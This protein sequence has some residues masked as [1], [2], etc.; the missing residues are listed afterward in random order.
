MLQRMLDMLPFP[1]WWLLVPV[2]VVVVAAVVFGLFGTPRGGDS[3]DVQ[4]GRSQRWA[5][6]KDLAPLLYDDPRADPRRLVL[7]RFAD[8]WVLHTGLHRSVAVVA[9]A[10]RGKTPRFV[11]PT[12]LRYPGPAFVTSTKFDCG[13]LTLDQREELGPVWLVDPAG[14]TGHAPARWSVLSHVNDYEEAVNIAWL[15][16]RS[17]RRVGGSASSNDEFWASMSRMLLG[18]CLLAASL[19][20]QSMA[21]VIR[22]IQTHDA[23]SVEHILAE[24]DQPAALSAWA[25]FSKAEE[26]TRA[27][28]LTSATSILEPWT[29]PAIARMAE[30]TGDGGP[31]IDLDRLLDENGTIY[32]I[33]S[34]EQQQ[35]FSPIF[36]LLAGLVVA[37][38]G[39]RSLRNGGLPISPPLL[40]LLDEAAN[41]CRVRDLD[42]W[43]SS[44]AGQGMILVS[45]WQDEAQ[46]VSAYGQSKAKE[47]MAN[48]A[49]TVYLPGISDTDTLATI[50]KKVGTASFQHHSSSVS[51]G[52]SRDRGSITRSS[53][54]HDVAPAS[55]LQDNLVDGQALL[56]VQG[57]KPAIVQAPGWWERD[58]LRALIPAKVAAGFDNLYASAAP[59]RTRLSRVLTG[60]KG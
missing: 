1:L 10:G 60:K 9:P 31:V 16:S 42:M 30:V 6:K 40:M 24:F 33:C 38:I 29:H 49:A 17:S 41:V 47:I 36:E 15:L 27:N 19:A 53:S 13:A 25:A 44:M 57:F 21:S 50:T 39:Q 56:F 37:L 22:W 55:W 48:H 28:M 12:L 52:A 20:G 58:E 26:R 4:R 35:M 45:V 43:A 3:L 11:I 32:L 14:Q 46:I 34:A 2:G 18:P 59:S 5:R 7:G 8:R 51:A 23:M 54:E